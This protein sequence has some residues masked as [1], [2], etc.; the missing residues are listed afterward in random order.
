M[1]SAEAGLSDIEAL[2]FLPFFIHHNAIVHQA[3]ER[4]R[5]LPY[6]QEHREEENKSLTSD[7]KLK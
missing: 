3:Q 1:C 6:F 2:C 7:S 5:N 4:M